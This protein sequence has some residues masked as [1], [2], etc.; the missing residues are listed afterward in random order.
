MTWAKNR[1]SGERRQAFVAAAHAARFAT[2]QQN[3]DH[4]LTRFHPRTLGLGA[5]R[6]HVARRIQLCGANRPLGALVCTTGSRHRQGSMQIKAFDEIRAPS[7]KP[8]ASA[9]DWAWPLDLA[10]SARASA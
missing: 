3:A 8:P 2:G 5:G 1:P 6:C 7:C 10:R 4:V 9:V